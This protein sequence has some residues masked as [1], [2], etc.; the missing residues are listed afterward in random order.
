MEY[1]TA[2]GID[3]GDKNSKICVM[4]KAGGA[5]RVVET[6]TI[7]TTPDAL[8]AYLAGKDPSWPVTFECGT[9]CRWMERT[10]RGT[11][12]RAIV[13]NPTRIRQITESNTK[14][15]R[16]DAR[17]LARLTLADVELLHPVRLRGEPYHRMLQ[18]LAARDGLIAV[19][20]QL[21]NQMRGFAKTAGFRLGRC[22]AG[23]VHALDRAEWP[24]DFEELTFPTRRL[25]ETLG[26]QIAAYDAMIDRLAATPDFRAMVERVGEIFGVGRIG[27]ATLVAEIGGDPGRFARARDAG[28]YFGLVPAQDQSGETDRQRRTTKAGSGFARRILV[29]LA[30]VVMKP[31]SRDTDLKLRGMR[32]CARG[33]RVARRKAV[34]AVA[35]GIAVAAVA[36]LKR[37]DMPYV[38]LSERAKAEFGRM[39]AEEAKMA[40]ERIR[41]TA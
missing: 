17:E 37:P 39:R 4:T 12:R 34:V 19:R 23:R 2:I 35:R 32:I 7:A 25:L 27:A 5:R 28:A 8:R 6:T 21:V 20:T 3:V 41:A 22:P 13:A 16:N 15:D 24:A 38:P 36:L 40:E 29:E 33:G 11:G 9:H 10:V 30:Q 31:N 14:N 26:E 18:L 1:D